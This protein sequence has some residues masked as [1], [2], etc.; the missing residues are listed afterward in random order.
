VAPS[1]PPASAAETPSEPVPASVEP[2]AQTSVPMPTT[3]A[4]ATPPTSTMPPTAVQA[5]L[6]QNAHSGTQPSVYAP[7]PPK[8][9]EPAAPVT[10]A[11]A[12]ASTITPKPAPVPQTKTET[13]PKSVA[14]TGER[15]SASNAPQYVVQIVTLGSAKAVSTFIKTHGL[16]DCHSFRQQRD[17]KELF[18]LTCGL[19]PNREAALAAQNQLPSSVSVAKPYPRQIADIRKVMLP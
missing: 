17:G 11:V 2:V 15:F 12:A 6:S 4:V 8:A 19:Y 13:K 14:Q 1:S 10:D 5:P 3:E 7:V 9:A 18:S 16:E